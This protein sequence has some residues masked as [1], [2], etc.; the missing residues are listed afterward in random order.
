MVAEVRQNFQFFRQITWFLGN[1]KDLS[2]FKYWTLHYL[3]VIIKL[4]ISNFIL[5]TRTTLSTKTLNLSMLKVKPDT[6]CPI[7]SWICQAFCLTL[8]KKF[9]LK[10]FQFL[11][12]LPTLLFL[13]YLYQYVFLSKGIS[14]EMR[15]SISLLNAQYELILGTIWVK[16]IKALFFEK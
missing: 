5:T 4:Q 3:I 1:N 7:K 10:F 8:L 12:F 9:R 11:L 6:K 15:Q 13:R 14:L 2:K 16:N